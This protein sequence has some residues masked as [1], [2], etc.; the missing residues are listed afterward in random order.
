MTR[1]ENRT[2]HYFQRTEID[3][4]TMTKSFILPVDTEIIYYLPGSR[5]MTCIGGKEWRVEFDSI[6]DWK[7]LFYFEIIL[8]CFLAI[9]C[10]NVVII[11]LWA[12]ILFYFEG[13]A[14][15][16]GMLA[17]S[18]YGKTKGKKKEIKKITK[19][20][21]L[22]CYKLEKRNKELEH[23]TCTCKSWID[24]QNNYLII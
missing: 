5:N 15:S 10:E 6:S 3:K 7:L 23:K 16:Y 13:H 4:P 19:N 9:S 14:I 24:Q 2:L 18:N 21:P 20:W 12:I 22:Y 17:S 11:K 1:E 8:F